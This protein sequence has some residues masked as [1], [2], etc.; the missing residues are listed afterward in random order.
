[1]LWALLAAPSASAEWLAGDLHVHTCFSHDAWCPAGDDNTA[2]DEFYTLSLGVEER[3]RQAALQGLDYLAISDHNDVRSSADPGF[4]AAGV[5]G[6]PAY[7]NSLDGHAQMLGAQLLYGT[8]AETA[9]EVNAAAA[10]LR[11]D[12]GA[13]Q[14]NHPGNQTEQR[15]GSCADSAVLDWDYGYDVQ[16]D[17][18]EVVNPTSPVQVAERWWECWLDRGARVG[19]TGGS[20]SHYAWTAPVQ[21][22]GQPTTWALADEPSRAGVLAA[23]RAGRTSVSRRAP[24]AGGAPLLLE[25]D[26]D[27]D[28]SFESGVGDTVPPGAVMRVRAGGPLQAGFVRVRG[29]GATLVDDALLPPGGAVE[30]RAPAE[31]GW[32]RAS[33]HVLPGT[34]ALDCDPSLHQAASLCPYDFLL[35]GLT[36]PVYVSTP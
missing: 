7:E 20:D 25:A 34:A 5:I 1:M 26:A 18:I 11:A 2:A 10:E 22:P 4:G 36:S 30:L 6:I 16:P 33:L 21:G 28:G 27:G 9:A 32:V 17:T 24:L 3:F 8:G 13:F 14:V 35:E 15:F 19:A 12:G 23:I 31:A 29:N